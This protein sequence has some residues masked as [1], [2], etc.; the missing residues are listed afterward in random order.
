MNIR[1][2]FFVSF[3][4]LAAFSAAPAQNTPGILASFKDKES[5]KNWISVNDG[6]MDGV[7]R[8]GYKR[9]EN[10]TLLFSGDLS[11]DN[12]GGFASIRTEPRPLNLTGASA[13]V[14]KARGDGRTYWAELRTS[15]QMGASSYRANLPTRKGEWVETSIPLADFKL[16]AFGRA[17]PGGAVNPDKVDSIGFTLADKMAGPF[18]LEIE[19]ISAVTAPVTGDGKTIA[20]LATAAGTFKTLLAAAVAA[21]LAGALS[22]PGPLTV[23]APTDE[24]F[25]KLPPGTVEELLKPEN[26]GK[27]ADIL[28]YHVIAGRVPLAKALELREGSTL[29]GAKLQATFT[30]GRVLIGGATLLQAD[31]EASNGLVH[32]IDQVLLPP[33][34]AGPPSAPSDGWTS[35]NPW[36]AKAIWNVSPVPPRSIDFMPPVSVL[37]FI[38]TPALHSTTA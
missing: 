12:N 2:F 7:S 8:G 16:Q 37:M 14:V 38:C 1:H 27:L 24:A 17:L 29:Q 23:F 32:V 21:D 34:A 15:G 3:S 28:K 30:D 36:P 33:A 6:V 18:E 35:T 22:G 20:D 31:L 4:V 10:G 11:L 13:I 5:L 26:K 9:T 19:Q 25:S